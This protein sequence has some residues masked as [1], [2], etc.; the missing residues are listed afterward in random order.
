MRY[1]LF[2]LQEILSFSLSLSSPHASLALWHCAPGLWSGP[3][4]SH[5]YRLLF[6]SVIDR[7]PVMQVGDL[8]LRLPV[9]AIEM[10]FL[11]L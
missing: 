11:N 6:R 9:I 10:D 7:Y 1:I 4:S 8:Q 5:S 2:I 3:L